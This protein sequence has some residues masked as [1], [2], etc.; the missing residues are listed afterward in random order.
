MH[1]NEMNGVQ[2]T[3]LPIC[4][5][6]LPVSAKVVWFDLPSFVYSFFFLC[7]SDVLCRSSFV[8]MSYAYLLLF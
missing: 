4:R 5:D 8:L 1:G 7:E 6:C 3:K 2:E